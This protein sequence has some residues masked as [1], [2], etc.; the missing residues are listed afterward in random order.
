MRVLILINGHKRFAYQHATPLYHQVSSGFYG[1]VKDME[2]KLI[3]AKRL[4]GKIE[5]MT[6]RLTSISKRKL[7]DVLKNK[8]D[9]YMTAEEALSLGVVDS[10]L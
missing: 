5:E 9:W 1:K 3:E 6:L 4:Q 2:E 10:I 7:N 8:V